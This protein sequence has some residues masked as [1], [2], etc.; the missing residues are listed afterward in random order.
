MCE[1]RY[2]V[3]YYQRS[4]IGAW[5]YVFR[6]VTTS[7][8]LRGCLQTFVRLLVVNILTIEYIDFQPK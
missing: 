1:T 7:E 2:L 5:G 3:A 8:W 4:R 6:Y